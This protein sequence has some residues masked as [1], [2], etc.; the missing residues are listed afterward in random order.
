MPR[1]TIGDTAVQPMWEEIVGSDSGPARRRWIIGLGLVAARSHQAGPNG[2]ETPSI[3]K[4]ASIS[5][6]RETR[7]CSSKCVP[8]ASP[9]LLNTTFELEDLLHLSV[10][11]GAIKHGQI[12][13]VTD[14]RGS[15]HQRHAGGIPANAQIP[16]FDPS[17]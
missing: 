15:E 13:Q 9:Q 2:C 11:Q 17:F 12:I 8:A 1:H 4:T 10:T 5:S 14:I 16:V 7:H 3:C 6:A